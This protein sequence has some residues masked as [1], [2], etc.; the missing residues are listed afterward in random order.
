MNTKLFALVT[1]IVSLIWDIFQ[2]VRTYYAEQIQ[3]ALY[4]MPPTRG[5]RKTDNIPPDESPSSGKG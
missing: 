3:T 1:T 4:S 2:A 5:S